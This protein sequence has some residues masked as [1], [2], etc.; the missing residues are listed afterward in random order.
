MDLPAGLRRADAHIPP[1]G[2]QRR[3]WK[4]LVQA[5]TVIICRSNP[6]APDPRVERTAETLS[7][8]GIS[9]L[10][11]AWDR[12][13]D[14]PAQEDRAGYRVHRVAIRGQ[15]GHGLGNLAPLVQWQLALFRQLV[16]RRHTFKAIHACDLDT[17]IPSLLVA[18]AW[19]KK[20]VFDIF[21]SYPDMVRVNSPLARGIARRLEQW[22]G[23]FQY[24]S[25][26][27]EGTPKPR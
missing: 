3:V 25:R 23:S 18:R 7:A 11:L 2:V 12:G 27:S 5:V 19:R 24:G 21:D 20:V 4:Q 8:A 1:A 17:V 26:S 15:F 14:L 10:V 9:T 16:S 13:W 22:A 6:V